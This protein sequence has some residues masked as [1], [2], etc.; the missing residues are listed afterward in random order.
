MSGTCVVGLQWGDE[1]KGKIVDLLGDQFDYVIRYNGGANAGHTVVANGKT[2]KLSLLPTG[3]IRPNVTSVIGNGVVVYPP[4][5]LE[6]VDQLAKG[7]IDVGQSLVLSD[8]AHVIFPYHMEEERLAESGSDGKIGTTG[9]GIGPCYQDK[10]GRRFGI[11]VGE[12]LHAEHLRERLA[13]IV[14][15]KNRLMIAFAN[16]HISSL[17]AFDPGT[18][19]DEYLGYAAKIRPYVTDTSRL[20]LNAVKAG[21]RVL[22]EAAQGSLLDVDHGTYPYVTSSSSLPSGIW[23]GSG[24]PAKHV[25]RTIGVVKAYTSRV[26]QGP[27]PTELNDG[28]EGIG[29]RIRRVGREYGTVTGRPRRTGWFDSVAVRYTASLAG[30]DEITIMLLDVLSGLPELR[31]CVGYTVAGEPRPFFS[32]DAYQL[33]QC[34]PV[35][36]T[37]DG[38]TQDIT[39]ARKL[40]DLPASARRYIDRIG[41]LVELPIT[42]VSVGPDREQTIRVK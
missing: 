31:I 36:E 32:S 25:T 33:E 8:H 35:Y 4:R 15:F 37:L 5:F 29:E 23:S 42:V 40:T 3:V 28:P 39:S 38:W 17:K 20:L 26:G 11:R 24:L 2:F 14:P 30:A 7:G 19:T 34:R 10:V 12:L 13:R 22:F 18:I 6:E 16:G 9:R 21:K 27:F 41:E 1:A